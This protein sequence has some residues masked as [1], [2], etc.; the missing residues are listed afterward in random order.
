MPRPIP[1]PLYPCARKFARTTRN[2]LRTSRLLRRFHHFLDERG[3]E[4][5]HT[6]AADLDR[7]VIHRGFSRSTQKSYRRLL[8][9][10]LDWLRRGAPDPRRRR[11]RRRNHPPLP[12]EA[13][14]FVQ[15]HKRP[16][17]LRGLLRR[18]LSFLGDRDPQS[19][20]DG[21]YE[22]F[23]VGHWNR[24]LRPSTRT[25]HRRVLSDYLRWLCLPPAARAFLDDDRSASRC[26]VHRFHDFLDAAQVD[27]QALNATHVAV[28]RRGEKNRN[29]APRVQLARYLEWL[30][31][32]GHIDLPPVPLPPPLPHRPRT[33]ASALQ[34]FIDEIALTRKLSTTGHYVT[35]LSRFRRFVAGQNVPL[36][37][38]RREHLVAW[39]TELQARLLAPSTRR[40]AIATV[41]T[42][43]RWLYERGRLRAHPDVLVRPSDFAKLPKYL[44]RPLPPDA[45]HEIQ[46]R[47]EER[48]D[49]DSLALLVQRRC[50]LRIGE[51]LRLDYNCLRFDLH[52]RAFL[53]VPLGKLD[54]E[55]LVPLNA[56]TLAVVRLLQEG[57]PQGRARLL[58][59]A[60]SDGVRRTRLQ[61]LL[62]RTSADLDI[63]EKVTT[64][65]LRHS[66][67]TE[68][69][70]AGMNLLSIM[71]LLGHR[72]ILM[73]LR[74]AD[75]TGDTVNGEFFA[76]LPQIEARY[77]LRPKLPAATAAADFDP[78]KALDDL[79]RWI[80]ARAGAGATAGRVRALRALTKRIDRLRADLRQ[81]ALK[82]HL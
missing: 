75:V 64:H 6:G 30:H 50:G 2:P 39:L 68:L 18:Y 10:Y 28:F 36:Q 59:D 79:A 31:D 25:H 61:H 69:L 37:R 9:R 8:G 5:E 45:D 34:P 77:Q 26:F 52:D 7:F 13:E 66:F 81:E 35:V 41:R 82:R 73:T 46:R 22:Q 71:K 33:I 53:K 43:L 24:Q 57:G 76:A 29:R 12:P 38:L 51:L 16:H 14:A 63:P 11:R 20:A 58:E 62:R 55:R 74:Y 3:L 23:L 40:A 49:P 19:L 47:L 4:P 65:R 27:L 67:A 1:Y 60:S 54:S 21:D 42:Y 48:G 78:I 44:P 56:A 17:L 72:S 15:S 70:S 80:H 32:R